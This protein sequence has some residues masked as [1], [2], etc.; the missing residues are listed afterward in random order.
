M[1]TNTY[2][3]LRLAVINGLLTLK[4]QIDADPDYLKDSPYDSETSEILKKLFE[5]KVVEKVVEKYI[6]APAKVGRGR[7]SKD[8]QLGE[9][10]EIKIEQE[11]SKLLAS[12]DKLDV[13][14]NMEVSQKIA[15][16]KNKR[17]L[18]ESILKMRERETT[19]RKT[20]EFK[21]TIIN[22]LQDLV[23]EK[24][25]EIFMKRLNGLR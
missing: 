6:Q 22:I 18:L 16:T 23:S 8:I 15:I 2:P 14:E 11:I 24:D 1:S 20:E 9:E 17:D 5:T 3:P 13:Q 7:P 21:E 12:L 25:R 19:V 10:D 4:Q